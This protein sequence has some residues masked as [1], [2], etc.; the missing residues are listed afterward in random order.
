MVRLIEAQGVV[1]HSAPA[2]DPAPSQA[3]REDD[4][5]AAGMYLK[6][7]SRFKNGKEH[8]YCSLAEEVSCASGRPGECL[9]RSGGF[10]V[11]L[12]I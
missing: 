2:A 11:S 7:H 9:E 4:R 3:G 8:H 10:K 1:F 5:L 12:E 6:C